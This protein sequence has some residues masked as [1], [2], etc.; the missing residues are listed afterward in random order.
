MAE[1]VFLDLSEVTLICFER[2]KS[3]RVIDYMIGRI[4]A[5]EV[6]P[7]VK[8]YKIDD[9]TYQL[10]TLPKEGCDDDGYDMDGGHLRA[11]AHYV[12]G[13]PLRCTVEDTRS[14]VE[15]RFQRTPVD[16][17]DIELIPNTLAGTQRYRTVRSL[18]YIIEHG[19]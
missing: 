8:V 3:D 19:P 17:K 10:T 7:A 14:K 4:R 5:G 2:Y 16:L 6:S 9:T 18:E 1:E 15:L 12:A 13:K 11:V